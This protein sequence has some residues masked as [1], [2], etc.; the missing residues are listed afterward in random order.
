VAEIAVSGSDGK[1]KLQTLCT[2]NTG[3]ILALVA[4]SRYGD[5]VEQKR[6]S[7][8]QVLSPE[9]KTVGCWKVKFT[10]Q[11]INVGPD[12][13]IYVAGD[14]RVAQFDREG[15]LQREVALPHMTALLK[16]SGELR[17][18]AEEQIKRQKESFQQAIDRLKE[19]EKKLKEI[20]PAERTDQ[21]KKQ[22]EQIAS[23]LE[24]YKASE[25]YYTKRTVDDIVASSIERLRRI[26][27]IAISAK[28]I[29]IVCG[30][31]KGYGY[32]IWRMDRDFQ[33]PTSILSGLSGCC[34]QMDVQVFG[35]DLLVAQNTRHQCA[36]Y[37]RDGKALGAWGKR[38]TA[39]ASGCFGGCCNPMN[40]RATPQGNIITAE[41]EG[42]VKCFSSKGDFLGLVG[43]ARLAGGCKH[44]AFG[45]SPDAQRIYFCDQPGSR[46]LV[47]AK[48]KGSTKE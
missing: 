43:L 19:R 41:S 2:D 7:E 28:D 34:G 36:R 30:E 47:L 6:P 48:K 20:K 15:T 22:L 1:T 18:Q 31:S 5:A 21:Q 33:N 25:K 24:N 29:F 39:T 32:A 12:D 3:R 35:E 4:P 17:R 42:F 11:A 45:V 8:V 40:V 46:V 38:G 9:G 23:L 26:N 16:D 13:T 37:S 10:A 44:V 14:G 27:S